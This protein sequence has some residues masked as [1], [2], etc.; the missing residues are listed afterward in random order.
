M[1]VE[2]I[3]MVERIL[4]IVAVVVAALNC[5]VLGSNSSKGGSRG[6]SKSEEQVLAQLEQDISN[7]IIRGDKTF[8]DGL[9]S[10]DFVYTGPSDWFTESV[11]RR[12]KS[13]FLSLIKPTLEQAIE[14]ELKDVTVR[15]YGSMA[16]LTGR[17]DIQGRAAPTQGMKKSY[18]YQDYFTQ[19]FARQ[20][21]HWKLIAWHT[22]R[23]GMPIR[24]SDARP[25]S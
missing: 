18:S 2:S 21:G 5:S 12:D 23:I 11:V 1:T 15:R 8:L 17:M 3:K 6:P 24:E 4:L 10:N 16:V 13:Q 25:K 22:S 7:A 9:I 20:K 14:I 19:T